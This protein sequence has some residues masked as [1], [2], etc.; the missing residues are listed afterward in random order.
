MH[1]SACMGKSKFAT[2]HI[3]M[4]ER[5]WW[6]Y[7]LVSEQTLRRRSKGLDTLLHLSCPQYWKLT[8]RIRIVDCKWCHG[9]GFFSRLSV[10]PTTRYSKSLYCSVFHPSTWSEQWAHRQWMHVWCHHQLLIT[11]MHTGIQPTSML[12]VLP[13]PEAIYII[14]DYSWS[15]LNMHVT[16]D[17]YWLQ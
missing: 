13:W 11:P 10:L 14:C 12:N 4:W 1:R 16:F 9:N 6:S 5:F 15:L 2:F 7:L 8:W 17:L 3:R